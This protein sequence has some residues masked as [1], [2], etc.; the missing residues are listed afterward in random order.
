MAGVPSGVTW[1]PQPAIGSPW[2]FSPNY[3]AASAYICQENTFVAYLTV[4]NGYG[5]N[6]YNSSQAVSP[7]STIAYIQGTCSDGSVMPAFSYNFNSPLFQ[8]YCSPLGYPS[9]YSYYWKNYN[10]L[11]MST[12]AQRI[13]YR[14][15][16]SIMYMRRTLGH[17][18]VS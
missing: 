1:V 16:P 14:Q 6:N 5:N 15:G 13:Y 3:T 9:S 2:L 7:N 10:G 12:F 4:L 18:Y 11:A 8:K 17:P